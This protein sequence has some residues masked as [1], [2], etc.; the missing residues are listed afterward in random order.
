MQMRQY[1]FSH[2]TL[3]ESQNTIRTTMRDI[4]Y[5]EYPYQ[6]DNEELFQFTERSKL[7]L[8]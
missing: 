3:N 5:N 8:K 1:R 2:K 6:G 7:D 4:Y